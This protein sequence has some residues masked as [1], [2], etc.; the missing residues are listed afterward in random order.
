MS[1]PAW[2]DE[3]TIATPEQM[4]ELGLAIGAELR[5]G[6]VLVLTGALGAGKTTLTRGI[7]EGMQ[8]RGPI[9]SPTFVLARTHPPVGGSTPL[10]HVDAYRLNDAHE[11][12]DLDLDFETSA[13]VI[14]WGK[15]LLD[16]GDERLEIT[17][18]RHTGNAHID[19]EDEAETR[20]VSLQG[21][22][23]RWS[24]GWQHA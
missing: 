6:D 2:E 17:L 8:V 19:T 18:V 23:A 20:V 7:G 5:A 13:V 14:E 1:E 24:K 12:D 9:T 10:V 16:D 22:G 15:G 3:L 11:L 4:H 21:Y